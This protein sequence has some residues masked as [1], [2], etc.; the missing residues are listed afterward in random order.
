MNAEEF[1]R[2]LPEKPPRPIQSWMLQEGKHEMKTP[3]TVFRAETV[4]Y[5]ELQRTMVYDSAE[6]SAGSKRKRMAFCKC[7]GCG[8]NYYTQ[9][10]PGGGIRILDG[11]DSQTYPIGDDEDPGGMGLIV[12]MGNFDQFLCPYCCE[13][14]TLIHASFLRGGRQKQVLF[15][16]VDNIGQYT[17]I[18]YFLLRCEITD[19]CLSYKFI[20]R[21]AIVL[22][23][24][25]RIFR[26]VHTKKNMF[27]CDVPQPFWRKVTN[28][29]EAD[30]SLYHDW[31]N[32]NNLRRGAQ[33]CPI[34]PDLS[35]TTG[36]KTAIEQYLDCRFENL[37]YAYLRTWQ[38][39]P[40]IELLL[41]SGLKK[42]VRG[43]IEQKSHYSYDNNTQIEELFDMGA[44][45]PHEILRMSKAALKAI[46]KR[47]SRFTVRA[48]ELWN[49]YTALSGK[50]EAD[51]FLHALEN[52][53][54]S[55]VYAV[56][57][58]M[59]DDSSM[60]FPR[61]DRYLAKHALRTDSVGS[62]LDTRKMAE[63]LYPGDAL[64][65][66]FLW[67]HNLQQTHDELAAQVVLEKN[68]KEAALLESGFYKVR[69]KFGCL[70]WT[71]KD[72]CIILPLSNSDLVREGNVLDHCVGTYGNRH[73]QG[74]CIFFVRHYR[75]P[76][77]P[78]YTLQMDL[79]GV[80]REI[81][82]HG[83]GNETHGDHKQYRHTIPQKVR[84]FVD[85]WKEEIVMPWFASNVA[86]EEVVA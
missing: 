69:Q 18:I 51:A 19:Y 84:T 12:E 6:A 37:P 32:I 81:Q 49:E 33:I 14:T 77:R 68:S 85:R 41:R 48:C 9:W 44:S 54:E 58:M 55:G 40:K 4:E 45:K 46:Q 72:L 21:E 31:G 82:L 66:R 24:R 86:K 34:M 83:Y 62:L 59:E 42:L 63:A 80:P 1:C 36:D 22:G 61:I 8:E 56:L 13:T 17:A 75:R 53:G 30:E 15:G 25:R 5:Q 52:Y 26:Y 28:R 64:P 70:E 10:V 60:D 3:I 29:R 11:E 2:L 47:P 23:N 71:D 27:H 67:P 50:L 43:L 38:K 73:V 16:Y 20:P 74:K 76:E 39:F 78:Y 7:L 57:E 65:P 35:G 79:T